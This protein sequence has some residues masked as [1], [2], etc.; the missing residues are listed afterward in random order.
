MV[1]RVW[2]FQ[3]ALGWG[4]YRGELGVW[5]TNSRTESISYSRLHS[6]SSFG[7]LERDKTGLV[8]FDFILKRWWPG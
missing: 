2:G 3:L 7:F 6:L 1:A 4:L 5:H 8:G